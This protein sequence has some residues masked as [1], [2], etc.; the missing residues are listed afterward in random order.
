MTKFTRHT[1]N[2]ARVKEKKEKAN[3]RSR[4]ITL[5]L[6]AVIIGMVVLMGFTYLVQVNR[7]STSGFEIQELEQRV[8]GLKK[9]NSKLE[10]EAARLESLN[11]IAE[12]V[13][14]LN[15]VSTEKVDYLEIHDSQ[16]AQK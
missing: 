5:N 4:L 11:A 12:R 14:E 1:I 9:E 10:L 6:Q 16:L 2:L 15:L 8:K 7:V 3:K 13:Q